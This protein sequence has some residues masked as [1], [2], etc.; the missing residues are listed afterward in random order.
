M[1]N[2][3][4]DKIAKYYDTVI[5]KGYEIKN[6]LNEKINKYKRNV[7]SVLE[8]GCGTGTNLLS[9]KK[10]IEV[11]GLDISREMLRIAK[12]KVPEGNFYLQDIRNFRLNKK[13]D[14]IICLYD[15]LN[16]ILIFNDWRRL[17][18]NIKKHLNYN[19]L[20]IFDINAI[21]RLEYI[22]AISPIVHEFD[23]NYLIVDVRKIFK[24]TF[25]WNLKIFE[26]KT[27]NEFTLLE[28]NIKESSFRIEKIAAELIKYFDIK[29]IEDENG[30]KVKYDSERIFFVCQ[31][32]DLKDRRV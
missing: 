20:F 17:F 26:K 2:P 5:G 21:A 16:H 3:D 24:N 22:S 8:L 14:L 7:K 9:F 23:T 29:R 15:T 19:G 25:N 18:S 12:K 13:F 32:N 27:K 1:K 6:Y 31:N 28:L 10:D 11:F 4:Y 30:R